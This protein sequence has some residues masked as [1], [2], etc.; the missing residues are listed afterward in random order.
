MKEIQTIK[1]IKI[2]DKKE[3]TY[4]A[5]PLVVTSMKIR[6]I[7]DSSSDSENGL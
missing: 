2:K 5:P 6:G 7:R 1:S 3:V 4:R